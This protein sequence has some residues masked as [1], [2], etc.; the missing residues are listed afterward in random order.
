M[1]LGS[2]PTL[3]WRTTVEFLI[4][5]SRTSRRATQRIFPCREPAARA[6]GVVVALAEQSGQAALPEQA[7]LPARAVVA[8]Y[9]PGVR[10]VVAA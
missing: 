3:P 1:V 9:P 10:P 2:T 8:E 7:A 6:V 5:H 4:A